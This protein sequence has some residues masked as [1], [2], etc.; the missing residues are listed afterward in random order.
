MPIENKAER[1]CSFVDALV[2][3]SALAAFL[4]H[5]NGDA[6]NGLYKKGQ[7][8]WQTRYSVSFKDDLKLFLIEPFV[9]AG[10]APQLLAS[11][12]E[13]MRLT[14]AK[15]IIS[16]LPDFLAS[17]SQWLP[18]HRNSFIECMDMRTR[19]EVLAL[20]KVGMDAEP[21]TQLAQ[22]SVI[23]LTGP[24]KGMVEQWIDRAANEAGVIATDDAEAPLKGMESIHDLGV[25]ISELNKQITLEPD[26]TPREAELIEHRGDLLQKLQAEAD[27]SA[28]PEAAFAVAAAAAATQGEDG[29]SRISRKYTLTDEQEAVIRAE[30]SIVVAAGAGSGKTGTLIAWLDHLV[31]NKG[32]NPERMALISFTRAASAEIAERAKG[33][34][35]ISGSYIGRTTHAIARTVLKSFGPSHQELNSRYK[36]K[37]REAIF[38]TEEAD[39][40][41]DIALKQVEM[42][43]P[44]GDDADKAQY[45]KKVLLTL[46]RSAAYPDFFQR[47]LD[48]LDR[49]KMLTTNQLGA[50]VTDKYKN[51]RKFPDLYQGVKDIAEGRAPGASK[52]AAREAK[53]K[54]PYMTQPAGMRFNIGAKD[55]HDPKVNVE[56]VPGRIRLIVDNYMSSGVSVEEA[57]KMAKD[58]P[59]APIVPAAAYDAYTWLKLNDPILGPAMDFTDQIV[60]ALKV[61]DDLPQAREAA[62]RMFDVVVVD[63]AQDLSE[64]QFRFFQHLMKKT[65]IG[66]YIG[67]DKQS[68]YRFRGAIPE[69]FIAQSKKSKLFQMTTNFR[70]GEAIVNAAN[71]L[72]AH[73]KGQIP[74]VCSA[75][76][77]KGEGEI[78]FV[79][80]ASHSE[81]AE[82]VAA[83]IAE[84]ISS[85]DSSAA[86]FGILVRNNAELDAYEKELISRG[87]PFKKL[88][89]GPMFFDKPLV[90]AVISWIRLASQV[91]SREELNEAVM[92]ASMFP[93]FGLGPSFISALA[94]MTP[95]NMSYVDYLQSGAKVYT[96]PKSA[97]K[98]AKSVAPFVDEMRAMMAMGGDTESLILAILEIKGTKGSLKKTLKEKVSVDDVA[99]SGGGVEE[100][101]AAEAEALGP[102]APILNIARSAPNPQAFLD[103]IVKMKEA[104]SKLQKDEENSTPAVLLGTVHTW[105]GLQ[106]PHVFVSMADGV[107][108]NTFLT[109]EEGAELE[110]ERRLAY[111]ALTRGQ[112]KVTVMAAKLNYR[113][114]INPPKTP[115]PQSPFIGEACLKPVG[116]AKKAF[117]RQASRYDSDFWESR[118]T[119]RS[120]G[121]F[122][123]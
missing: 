27:K 103:F 18:A 80:T 41:W 120:S 122:W 31:H 4:R 52:V 34:A 77:K 121:Y 112:S 88:R 87:I 35:G 104:N 15:R 6:T 11:S 42:G 38:K 55:L 32:I 71:Q 92:H 96:D 82:M 17:F 74:M 8:L 51:L 106:A 58:D 20:A 107:F 13:L 28:T 60:L 116:T 23:R 94:N 95:S 90:R 84:S 89:P 117:S 57:Y 72:I 14:Q 70:S 22:L 69:N 108:P 53:P 65:R 48:Q 5:L 45:L 102:L 3:G 2:L 44:K 36:G 40:L 99:S 118:E 59:Y 83:S 91:G 30:G 115:P 63:E 111:V 109:G 114:E 61:L 98:N 93:S 67:D 7:Q 75:D 101:E 56:M 123:S 66:A 62:Q 26:G 64:V 39:K 47:L 21:V 86:D 19:T 79:R 97:W 16:I 113:A 9:Q 10:K 54:S 73:N 25:Q 105:K 100:E 37:L 85:G 29:A 78:G 50:L 24:N 46:I 1:S 119:A 81:S 68:I 33:R 12:R 76:P 43:T 49:G 110:E